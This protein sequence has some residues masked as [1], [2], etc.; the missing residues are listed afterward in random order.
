MEHVQDRPLTAP[1]T[2]RATRPALRT[3]APLALWKLNVLRVGYLVMG[4]GLALV[5]W[6]LLL[7]HASWTLEEGTIECLLVAMSFLALL[8]V[9]YPIRM[10]PILMFEVTWKL[11][12]LG[13]VALPQWSNH[14]LDA[15]TSR[16]TGIILWVVI[17]IAVIPWRYVFAQFVLAPADP[18]R[19]QR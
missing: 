18:W 17:I 19:R 4:L 16:Q 5:K 14:D 3:L 15:A 1:P 8:G 9:R 10:L 2:A 13:I 11:L 7:H 6:P 12:W